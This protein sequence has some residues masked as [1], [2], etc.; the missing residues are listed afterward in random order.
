MHAKLI[1]LR[2]ENLETIEQHAESQV[3]LALAID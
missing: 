2:A 1:I 3:I